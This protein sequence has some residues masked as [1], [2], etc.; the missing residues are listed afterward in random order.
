MLS[1]THH[2]TSLQA[3]LEDFYSL[4][5]KLGGETAEIMCHHI[6]RRADKL[7]INITYG[8]F[9]TDL[10]QVRGCHRCA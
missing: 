6:K 5:A 3:Y 1:H 8:S 10:G 9:D 2:L 4:C 7:V